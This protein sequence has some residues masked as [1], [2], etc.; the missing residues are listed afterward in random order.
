MTSI[1]NRRWGIAW[2][3]LVLALALHVVDEALTGF[4]PLYNSVVSSLRESYSWFPLPTF[5]FSAWITGLS[6]GILFLS[7]LSPLAFAGSRGL[8]PISYFLGVLMIANG[9][10]HIGIT[11]Y[12]GRPAPGVYSSPIVLVAAFALLIATYRSNTDT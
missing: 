4:L 6:I 5:S 2:V 10:G 7:G 8:R 12:L 3:S 1:K 11:I 9:L